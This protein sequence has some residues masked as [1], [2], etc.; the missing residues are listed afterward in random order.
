M[1]ENLP[2]PPLVVRFGIT[3]HRKVGDDSHALSNALNSVFNTLNEQVEIIHQADHQKNALSLYDVKPPILRLISGLAAG[4]DQLAALNALKQGWQV[5]AVLPFTV[6]EFRKD[7]MTQEVPAEFWKALGKDWCNDLDAFNALLDEAGPA[8]I[9]L[10][11]PN[12]SSELRNRSYL[13]VGQSIVRR[14]ETLVAIWDGHESGGKGGTAEIVEFALRSGTPVVWICSHAPEKVRW[15][16]MADDY[17]QILLGKDAGKNFESADIQDWLT[18][19]LLPQIKD[20]SGVDF[21]QVDEGLENFRDDLHSMPTVG[22]AKAANLFKWVRGFL[23]KP[24][25]GLDGYDRSPT[26]IERYFLEYFNRIDPRADYWANC[27]RSTYT[28]IIVLGALAI[29]LAILGAVY[30]HGFVLL[31]VVMLL[32]VWWL[33]KNEKI[34]R[35][36]RRWMVGRIFSELLRVARW[37]A[38]LGRELPLKA[39]A[40]AGYVS[41]QNQALVFENVWL[42]HYFNAIMRAAPASPMRLDRINMVQVCSDIEKDLICGQIDYHA[43]N[44]ERS[45]HISHCLE[46]FAYKAFFATCAVVGFELVIMVINV[47]G[48]CFH[49]SILGALAGILPTIAAATAAFCYQSEFELLAS[50]SKLMENNLL[51]IKNNL[52]KIGDESAW[53][54]ELLAEQLITTAELMIADVADWSLVFQ[55]KEIKP[56]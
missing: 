51:V 21:K 18:K 10:C 40:G 32:F 26:D 8:C 24:S 45:R 17:Y 35:Y 39:S 34:S 9:E 42:M 47:F 11:G 29:V 20:S 12:N 49:F 52:E 25:C 55:V 53:T 50:R 22:N 54:A 44:S 28:A 41:K 4:A 43:V 30:W 37:M 56:S 46:S 3:G 6:D 27:Y 31:E 1:S 38:L 33:Y 7:F 48:F 23:S 19:L 15:L 36:H 16:Q 13:A 2:C 14:A 5:E